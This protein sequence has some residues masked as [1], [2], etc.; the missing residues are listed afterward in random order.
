MDVI[1]C[2][3][4][5]SGGSWFS[6]ELES[7]KA[8]RACQ[9]GAEG[10]LLCWPCKANPY[11][12]HARVHWHSLMSFGTPPPVPDGGSFPPSGAAKSKKAHR[13]LRYF[14]VEP[15]GIEPPSASYLRPVLHA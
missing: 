11:L 3:V 9:V 2:L 14:L 15:G 10:N 5:R 7:G 1:V 13:G 4:S 8:L 12:R 6:L